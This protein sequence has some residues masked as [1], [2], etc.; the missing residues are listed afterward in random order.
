ML[1]SFASGECLAQR[2]L[3]ACGELFGDCGVRGDDIETVEST[4]YDQQLGGDSGVEEPARV[5]QVFFDEQ[6]DGADTDPR[7]R[8]AVDAGYSRRHGGCRHLGRTCGNAEKRAPGK[9]VAFR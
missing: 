5:L 4:G 6:V 2:R 9:T 8:Q 7:W 3:P 1:N